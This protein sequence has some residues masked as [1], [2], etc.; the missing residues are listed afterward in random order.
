M[1]KRST[2]LLLCCLLSNSAAEDELHH[3]SKRALL[4][5]QYTV[6]QVRIPQ[7]YLNAKEHLNL[8]NDSQL[9]SGI[10]VPVILPERSI[11]LAL[12]VLLNYDLPYNISNFMP[13]V[14]SARNYK[15]ATNYDLDRLT[16]YTHFAKIM[17]GYD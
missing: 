9:I 1:I 11:N 3:L 15:E 5:P 12:S 10:A 16:L 6:L 17:D 2:F 13:V 14:V 4:F 8:Q 7:R